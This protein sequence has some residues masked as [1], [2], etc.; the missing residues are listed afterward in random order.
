MA[1]APF[2]PITIAHP[3]V[4][5][6]GVRICFV[7]LGNICRSPAAAAV[8]RQRA[9]QAGLTV[10]VDSAGTSTYHLGEPA[11]PATL[12]EA[13]RRGIPVDHRAR[14]FTAADFDR[15]DLVVAMDG[16]NRRD[17]LALAPDD[18]ARAKVVLLRSFAAD[19][20]AGVDVPDPWGMEASVY[21]QMFDLIEAG[22]DG[23]VAHVAAR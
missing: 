3:R 19:A 14:Q 1:S 7:C 6:S 15:F 12:A 10:A 9:E 13:R 16:H 17:L 20:G 11:H 2:M 18:E 4:I 21:A 5:L 23:L 22:C 8:F